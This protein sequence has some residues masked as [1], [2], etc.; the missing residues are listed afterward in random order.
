MADYTPVYMYG[1]AL[2][3][4]LS[5]A[6]V[7]GDLL[8]V[9]GNG[10]VRPWVPNATPSTKVVGVASQDAAVSTR[11]TVWG[12]GPVHESIADGTVTAGDQITAAAA[13]GR[14]VK[15]AA[16]VTTPTPADVTTTRAIL[17]VALT[18]AADGIKVRWMQSFG[19]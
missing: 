6:C 15:T 11:V 17:G 12:F 2:T 18:T 14:Q 4:T 16:A 19:G 1:R 8:E 9:S 7:G 3:L 5:V 13:A 10:T